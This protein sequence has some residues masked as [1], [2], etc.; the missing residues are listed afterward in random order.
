MAVTPTAAARTDHAA[1]TAGTATRRRA[2]GAAREGRTSPRRQQILAAAAALFARRGFHGV[3]VDDLGAAAGVSGP[4]LYRH[5]RSKEAILAELLVGVSERLLDGGR[6]RVQSAADPRAAL[7]ALVEWHVEFALDNADV[8]SVQTRDLASLPAPERRRVRAL[9]QRYVGV[10][11]DVVADVTGCDPETAVAAA[12]ATFGLINST[13]HSARLPRHEMA[14]LLR[15]MA[16]A[17]AGTAVSAA[18]SGRGS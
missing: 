18:R 13:P 17:A 7:V 9:Q 3:S 5:F 10:W 14:A 6:L 1:R 12:H 4:A 11:A 8:I 2:G 16:V 15:A